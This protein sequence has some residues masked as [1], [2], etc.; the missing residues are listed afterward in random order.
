[1]QATGCRD[2]AKPTGMV[3]KAT[4]MEGRLLLMLAS[5]PAMKGRPASCDASD[6]MRP[7]KNGAI[8]R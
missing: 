7:S 4:L 3:S 1:M 2:K 5:L 8:R 6:Q